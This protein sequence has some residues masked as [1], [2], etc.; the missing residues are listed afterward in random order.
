MTNR[1]NGTLYCGVTN[2]LARRAWEHREGIAPGFT[3]Q[4]GLTRLV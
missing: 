3:R 4:Y 1:Q 2:D